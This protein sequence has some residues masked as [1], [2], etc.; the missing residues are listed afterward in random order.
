MLSIQEVFSS[1][2]LMALEISDLKSDSHRIT[3][4][5]RLGALLSFK[6]HQ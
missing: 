1:I 5:F 6:D 4:Q 3:G 2:E